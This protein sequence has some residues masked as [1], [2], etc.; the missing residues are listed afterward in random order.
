MLDEVSDDV[1]VKNHGVDEFGDIIPLKPSEIIADALASEKHKISDTKVDEV[2]NEE[3]AQEMCESESII[4]VEE[5][6]KNND[7]SSDVSEVRNST[8]TISYT[9]MYYIYTHN[10]IRLKEEFANEDAS[11]DG[12]ELVVTNSVSLSNASSLAGVRVV[13]VYETE[14]KHE[15]FALDEIPRN[16][17]VEA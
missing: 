9:T 17:S 8:V 15:F 13:R 11:Y 6:A 5:N 14:I 4:D 1:E 16:F 3:N 10:Q 12:P 2:K 7:S